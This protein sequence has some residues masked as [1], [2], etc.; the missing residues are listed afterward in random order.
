MDLYSCITSVAFPK[1]HMIKGSLF[2]IQPKK[3]KSRYRLRG[4]GFSQTDGIG[5]FS[6]N[7]GRNCHRPF[8][9]GGETV[10]GQQINET[11]IGNRS[12]SNGFS[13]VDSD[14]NQILRLPQIPVENG[15]SNGGYLTSDKKR[16][17][18]KV[19]YRVIVFNFNQKQNEKL[20]LL[21]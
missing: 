2:Y 12:S 15:I 20:Q 3:D 9:S 17:N 18:Q 21:T 4:T 7:Y 6:P 8:S 14:W 19:T 16:T 11:G 1:L 13:Y 10:F 5:Q